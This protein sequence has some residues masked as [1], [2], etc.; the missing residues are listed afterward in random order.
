MAGQCAMVYEVLWAQGIEQELLADV[1]R[2]P[3]E[4]L[5]CTLVHFAALLFRKNGICCPALWHA[6]AAGWLQ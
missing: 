1:Q 2:N 4:V 6:L 5:S 3:L